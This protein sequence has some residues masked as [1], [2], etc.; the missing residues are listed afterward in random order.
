MTATAHLHGVV[1]HPGK[2]TSGRFVYKCRDGWYWQCDLHD[3]A[4]PPDDQYGHI[5]TT[6]QEAFAGAIAHAAVCIP[7]WETRPHD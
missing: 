6:M 4:V 7:Y 2:P 5:V 1:R 3:E